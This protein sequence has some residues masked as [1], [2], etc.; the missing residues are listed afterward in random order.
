MRS[1]G[2]HPKWRPGAAEVTAHETALVCRS[3]RSMEQLGMRLLT[4]D[5]YRHRRA[6]GPGRR[7][8]LQVALVAADLR[9]PG[10][11]TDSIF[12]LTVCYSRSASIWSAFRAR[13]VAHDEVRHAGDLGR[14]CGRP[15]N[16]Q[17]RQPA[18]KV[19]E[20]PYVFVETL[21]GASSSG[22]CRPS[23]VPLEL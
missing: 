9:H 12:G 5:R 23:M 3:T 1:V 2:R 6:R 17:F 19:E 22:F 8:I 13:V 7:P 14:G 20:E 10:E 15:G 11:W 4:N 18:A 16:P 21:S